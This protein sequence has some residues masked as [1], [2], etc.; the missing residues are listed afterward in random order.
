MSI[1]NRYVID[2]DTRTQTV[3]DTMDTPNNNFSHSNNK[4]KEYMS[5]EDVKQFNQLLID[6]SLNENTCKRYSGFND[7]DKI[8]EEIV[9]YFKLCDRYNTIPTVTSLG[10]YLGISESNIILNSEDKTCPIRDNLKSALIT[11]HTVLQNATIDGVVNSVLYIYLSKAQY[12]LNDNTVITFNTNND[13]TI[14][15]SSTMK[16]LQQQIEL[17][18][19]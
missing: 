15:T 5:S 19:K 3:I 1:A 11:C 9:E 2:K 8:K 14:S 16:A 10:C 13:N 7:Y 18:K 4:V 12:G 6:K 17:E